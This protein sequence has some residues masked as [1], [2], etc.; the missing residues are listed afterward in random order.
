MAGLH[1]A[2]EGARRGTK[3]S[4]PVV[5]FHTVLNMSFGLA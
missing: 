5:I 1:V 4:H 2:R 3:V